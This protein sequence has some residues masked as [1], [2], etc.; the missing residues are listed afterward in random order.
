M[1]RF[2]RSIYRELSPLVAGKP[3]V[4]APARQHLLEACEETMRR[5]AS[6]RRYFARPARTLF[7]DVRDHFDLA[8]QIRVLIVIDRYVTLAQE[9][10]AKLPSG[11]SINGEPRECHANTRRGTPCRREP[12]PER[13]YCPSHK[14]LEEIFESTAGVAAEPIPA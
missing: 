13:D 3:D 5:L 9:H 1:Y 2:S 12:L 4:A 8:Q 7:T 10:L 6:D 14:H 11:I